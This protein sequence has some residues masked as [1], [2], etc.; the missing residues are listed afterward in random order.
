MDALP[1]AEQQEGD[2]MEDDDMADVG[3]GPRLGGGA[4]P[5]PGASEASCFV[6]VLQLP[7]T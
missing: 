6:T 1:S 7:E 3:P 4:C 2:D 5:A